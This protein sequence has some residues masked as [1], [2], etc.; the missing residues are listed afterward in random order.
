MFKFIGNWRQRK[1]EE[2]AERQR[3]EEQQQRKELELRRKK[4]E[5]QQ[6]VLN[7][8]SEGKVL[9]GFSEEWSRLFPAFRLAKTESLLYVF[10]DVAYF[11]RVVRRRVEGRS[12]GTSVRVAKGV[13]IRMGRSQ[14]T[15]VEYEEVVQRGRGDMAITT[16]H[17]FFRGDRRSFRIPMGKVVTADHGDDYIE[18][19]RERAS[20]LP[21]YFGVTG[22]DAKF[23]AELVSVASTSDWGRAAPET[24]SPEDEGLLHFAAESADWA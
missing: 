12:A 20:G 17:I 9:E 21:E 13:S 16:K 24:V 22:D 14:G 5:L 10:P 18:V 4:S 7:T 11:E 1:A 3:Q 8:L 2:A 6:T 23:G 19:V 15:P